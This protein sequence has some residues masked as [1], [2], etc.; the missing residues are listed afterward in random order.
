MHNPPY[1]DCQ[2]VFPCIL[3]SFTRCLNSCRV[4]NRNPGSE[5]EGAFSHPQRNVDLLYL[6]PSTDACS[7]PYSRHALYATRTRFAALEPIFRAAF[8]YGLCLSVASISGICARKGI[9]QFDLADIGFG[10]LEWM[11]TALKNNVQIRH[12]KE[13]VGRLAGN[14]KE[15]YHVW[16][17]D[18]D[19]HDR[20]PM[21]ELVDAGQEKLALGKGRYRCN[22]SVGGSELCCVEG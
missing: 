20:G 12:P 4:G 7:C 17:E 2:C 15:R 18:A 22:L 19:D 13:E 21:E 9:Q 6:I 8:D 5:E 14:E 1:H 10:V 11:E 3:F 16:I